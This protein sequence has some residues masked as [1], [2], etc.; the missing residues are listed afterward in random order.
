MKEFKIGG[1]MKKLMYHFDTKDIVKLSEVGG[2][3]KSLMETTTIGLNVPN[4]FVLTVEFFSS[5]VEDLKKSEI[6]SE[7]L[8]E[9]SRENCER[10]KK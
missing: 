1:R 3:A 5:W 4:G 2:K 10:L 9:P 7:F 8:K 6:W